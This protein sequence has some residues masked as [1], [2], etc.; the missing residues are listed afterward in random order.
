[1]LLFMSTN[2]PHLSP[3]ESEQRVYELVDVLKTMGIQYSVGLGCFEGRE[4][5]S[6]RID[7]SSPRTR[8]E[9]MKLARQ[10]EQDC[11]LLTHKSLKSYFVVP[12]KDGEPS[13]AGV[14]VDVGTVKPQG[15]WSFFEGRYFQLKEEGTK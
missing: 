13:Q 7:A 4:E 6:F 11:V 3:M 2:R 10:F 12:G 1:M 9:L 14:L 8:G 5:T 15:D